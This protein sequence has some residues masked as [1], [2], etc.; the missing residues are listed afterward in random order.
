MHQIQAIILAAGLG[1]R[2]HSTLPKVLHPVCGVPMIDWAV[3]A[4]VDAGSGTPYVVVGQGAD[5]VRSHLGERAHYL[6]QAE[7]LGTGH[8]VMTARDIL[9]DYRGHVYVLA[10]DTPLL[11]ADTLKALH[12]KAIETGS[13]AVALTARIDDPAGYGRIVRDETGA[14]QAI[15]EDK[16]ATPAQKAIPEINASIYCFSAPRLLEALDHLTNDN[17]QKEYYLTDTLVIIKA[18]G[19]IV[20]TLCLSDPEEIMGIND[21]AQLSAVNA[22]M[23]R[24]INEAHMRK[25]VTMIDPANTY[26]DAGVTIGQDTVIYPGNV[27]E[28]ATAIGRGCVLYPGSRIA[29]SVIGDGVTIQSSVILSSHVGEG[30]VIGPAAHLRPGS[31]IGSHVRI[32]NFVETKNAEIGDYTKVSHLTYVGDARIGE[33]TNVGCGVVFVN[34]D[35]ERKHHTEVGSHSFIG[36]NVNLVAPVEVADNTYIAAGSTITDKVEEGDLA[37]ARARQVNKPGWVARRKQNKGE[38][39]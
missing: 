32:G 39:T 8:A 36:C 15:V 20:E 30:T 33:H 13:D 4:A 37:I 22:I 21:R 1:K 2:M 27:L 12:Q 31:R 16:D 7:P 34:Y 17:A 9:A 28:G 25:G 23:R 26:I 19:G 38:R 6:T 24:R 14:F 29:D 11:R 35:G 5:A 10:G 3:K 18:A